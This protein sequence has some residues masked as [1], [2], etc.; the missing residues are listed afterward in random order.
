MV[1]PIPGVCKPAGHFLYF[2]C[3]N[4]SVFGFLLAN[5]FLLFQ[6]GLDVMYLKNPYEQGKA[7]VE[8]YHFIASGTLWKSKRS[9]GNQHVSTAL[10]LTQDFQ[11]GSTATPARSRTVPQPDF[12][13]ETVLVFGPNLT[14]HTLTPYY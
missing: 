2:L 14:F 12:D 10:N 8:D 7:K 5:M 1:F 3:F 9:W 13:E 6:G 11:G 4:W